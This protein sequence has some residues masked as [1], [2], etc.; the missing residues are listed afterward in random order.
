M[1]STYH[2]IDVTDE[3]EQVN[4]QHEMIDTLVD[5][6]LQTMTVAT[7]LSLAHNYLLNEYYEKTDEQIKILYNRLTG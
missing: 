1:S 5:H 3:A 4:A 7:L 6:A 2:D